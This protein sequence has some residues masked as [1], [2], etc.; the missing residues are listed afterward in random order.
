MKSKLVNN[1]GLKAMSL[2]FAIVLWA[3]VMNL[4]DPVTTKQFT[5][6]PVELV[7]TEVVTD[8]GK[9]YQVVDGEA[10]V[11]VIVEA[12]SSVLNS[13]TADDIV[14]T[15]DF[16]NLELSTLVPVDVTISGYDYK[17]ITVTPVNLEVSIEDSASIKFPITPVSVGEV[18]SE[19]VLGNLTVSEETVSISGA[20]S[21]VNSIAQVVAQVNVDGITESADLTGELILYDSDNNMI[22]QTLLTI[23]VDDITVHAEVQQT[24]TVSLELDTSGQPAEGYE[25]SSVTSVPTEIVITGSDEDLESVSIIRIPGTALNVEGMAG[26]VEMVIDVSDYL[27]EGIDL[28]DSNA[29]SIA[30]TI[31]IDKVGTKSFEIPVESIEVYSNPEDM[32]FSYDTI[33]DLMIT[34]TGM[35]DV[36]VNLTEDDIRVSIDLKSYTK[37]GS[38]EVPVTVSPI[39]DCELVESITVPIILVSN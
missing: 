20:E 7:N 34:F 8:R 13:L 12:K 29:N 31:Q 3:V 32:T 21:V 17:R 38:Y 16:K 19:Y 37:P 30:V 36:I 6:I 14:A 10:V 26:K 2:I 9:V 11:T 28:V 5:N 22:D 23:K 15:G 1:F 33:E 4:A 39:D 18:D 24:K 35:E 25:I 27:P